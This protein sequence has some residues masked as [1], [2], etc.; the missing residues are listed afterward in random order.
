LIEPTKV[1]PSGIDKSLLWLETLDILID[2][3]VC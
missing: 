2:G 3:L 1:T